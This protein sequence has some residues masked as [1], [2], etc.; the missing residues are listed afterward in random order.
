MHV[1]LQ[2]ALAGAP[3]TIFSAV[4]LMRQMSQQAEEMTLLGLGPTFEYG[5]MVGGRFGTRRRPDAAGAQSMRTEPI[6]LT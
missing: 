1:A 2:A 4:R 3:G 5:A 6:L